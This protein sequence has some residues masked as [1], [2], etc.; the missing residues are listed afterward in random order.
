MDYNQAWGIR[1]KRKMKEDTIAKNIYEE[2]VLPYPM[3]ATKGKFTAD[4]NNW[5]V[6][7]MV[8][9]LRVLIII[10]ENKIK[11]FTG[12]KK[13]IIFNNTKILSELKI[14]KDKFIFDALLCHETIPLNY[15]KINNTFPPEEEKKIKC[16][17]VDVLQ[18][19]QY[20]VRKLSL[21][22]RKQLL[23]EIFSKYA[24]RHIE[25]M[26]FDLT[27]S[28]NTKRIC[29]KIQQEGGMIKN[30]FSMYD[31]GTKTERWIKIN[32]STLDTAYVIGVSYDDEKE[33]NF[34]GMIL[35]LPD[36]KSWKY[37]GECSNG[38]TAFKKEKLLPQ[39]MTHYSKDSV[40]TKILVSSRKIKWV[41]PVIKIEYSYE[42]VSKNG[43]KKNIF[44][45]KVKDHLQNL[46]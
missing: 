35:G 36:D 23:N 46:S 45:H 18:I 27:D 19:N 7:P 13:Q 16:I 15:N 42:K 38:L 44:F 3:F 41:N 1:S 26:K 33:E 34:H 43:V 21:V 31:S 8:K 37:I 9:G 4:Y 40:L 25:R 24:W 20:D 2:S 6:E 14:I 28:K 30:R 32:P 5:I 10:T 22:I 12:K 39:I 11:F 17:L 29:N